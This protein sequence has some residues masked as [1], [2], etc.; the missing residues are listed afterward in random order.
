MCLLV[1]VQGLHRHTLGLLSDALALWPNVP[2]KIHFLNK[3]LDTNIAQGT[4]D[5]PPALVTGK[6]P[7]RGSPLCSPLGEGCAA[8]T[9]RSLGSTIAARSEACSCEHMKVFSK[10]VLCFM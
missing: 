9:A 10:F 3:L 8:Y 5:P 7:S 6:T 4:L 2:V 1:P